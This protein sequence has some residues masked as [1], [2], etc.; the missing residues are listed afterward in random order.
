MPLPEPITRL[1]AVF[2]LLKVLTRVMAAEVREAKEG[3]GP[4]LPG[5]EEYDRLS[6]SHR[7]TLAMRLEADA[8]VL[9]ER[10]DSV[11]A[12]AEAALRNA[13]R[14]ADEPAESHDAVLARL[15]DAM[16]DPASPAGETLR[17]LREKLAPSAGPAVQAKLKSERIQSPGGSGDGEG[18]L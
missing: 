5:P 9:L 16:A 1:L 3:L 7:P 17:R 6:E 8:D 15:T 13:A 18:A 14:G 11:I 2:A 4:L 12:L 10:L